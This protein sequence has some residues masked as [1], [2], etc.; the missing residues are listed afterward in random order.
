R[1]LR[2]RAPAGQRR[3]DRTLL[4]AGGGLGRTVQRVLFGDALS[5]HAPQAVASIAFRPALLHELRGARD[6]DYD[7]GRD[8][9]RSNL[10]CR[11]VLRA[12][13]VTT[14]SGADRVFAREARF[15]AEPAL[16]PA[17]QATE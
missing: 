11:G 6:R 16:A 2:A 12:R 15:R 1:E 10:R 17:R 4:A 3:R 7:R 8:C 5:R 9:G 13:L 14:V